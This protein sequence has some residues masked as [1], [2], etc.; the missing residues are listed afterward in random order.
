MTFNNPEDFVW[1]ISFRRAI[2]VSGSYRGIDNMVTGLEEIVGENHPSGKSLDGPAQTMVRRCAVQLLVFAM[3]VS[4]VVITTV[5][6]AAVAQAGVLGGVD[7]DGA[8]A[9]CRER[10]GHNGYNAR[11]QDALNAYSWGCFYVNI[12]YKGG[13]DF[14]RACTIKYGKP[15]YS[16][17]NNP[18]WA[19]SWMCRR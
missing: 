14:N 19:W 7:Y 9:Y 2:T 11:P 8:N 12:N 6:T 5:S 18:G 15:A 16:Y 13:V 10:Y 3:L 4:A 1:E 17:S